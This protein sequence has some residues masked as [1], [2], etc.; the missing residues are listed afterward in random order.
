MKKFCEQAV[1][2]V[3]LLANKHEL[4]VSAV[5]KLDED[6]VV[7]LDVKY[8]HTRQPVWK[9]LKLTP[10]ERATGDCLSCRLQKR[11]Y[12]CVYANRFWARRVLAMAYI[13]KNEFVVWQELT[14]RSLMVFSKSW[15][16]VTPN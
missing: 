8:L 3:R 6:D 5:K 15:L 10:L 4:Y 9:W 2:W 13:E 12:K 11:M 14:M 16:I 1:Y 7:S